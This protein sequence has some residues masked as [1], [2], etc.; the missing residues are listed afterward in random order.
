MES[1]FG[2]CPITW[3]FYSIK[4]NSEINHIHK[5]A[6]RIVY[7]GNISSYEELLK[8]D[9]SFC[10]HQ[11]NIQSFDMEP[12]KVKS[13]LSNKVIWDIF[14]TRNLNYNLKLQTDFVRTRVNKLVENLNSFKKKTRNWKPKR[15]HC[16]LSKKYA[17]GL[18]L[19][20]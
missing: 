15:C 9:K 4:A 17:H 18:G 12:F 20:V 6:F 13:N 3:L 1:Q 10:I 8:K 7:K 19:F 2:Y 11:R 5:S 14:E 16:R